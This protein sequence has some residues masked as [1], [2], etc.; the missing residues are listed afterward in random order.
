M[1]EVTQIL[2][3]CFLLH[4]LLT[5]VVSTKRTTTSQIP[6]YPNLPFQLMCQVQNVT[7]HVRAFVDSYS[8]F[9][10]HPVNYSCSEESVAFPF[11][12]IFRLTKIQM[13]SMLK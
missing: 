10:D 11:I 7:L 4:F 1:I 8:V 13:K 9:L 6:N 3:K 2:N 12:N 5:G